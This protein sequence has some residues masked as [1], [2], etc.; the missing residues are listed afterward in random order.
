MKKLITTIISLMFFGNLVFAQLTEFSMGDILS[1]GA[2]NQNFKYLENRFGGIRET[3][4]NCGTSGSGSG[5]NSAIQNGYNSIVING[6][7][8]ENIKL[9]GREGN[10]PRLLKLRGANNDYTKDKIIDNSSYTDHVVNVLFNGIVVT[11]DNLTLSG[12]IRTVR[13]WGPNMFRMENVKVNDYKQRGIHMTE[14]SVIDGYNLIIDGS[15][16]S[17]DSSERGIWLALQSYGWFENLQISNNT[18]CGLCV[19]ENSQTRLVGTNSFSGNGIGI[20][21]GLASSLANSSNITIDNSADYGVHVK[22]GMVN[23]PVGFGVN[24]SITITNTTSGKAFNAWLSNIAISDLTATGDGSTEESLVVINQSSSIF[25]NLNI[26]NS[27]NDG[28]ESDQSV[29]HVDKLTAKNNQGDGIDANSTTLTVNNSTISDN[30]G[31]GISASRS[32]ITVKNSVIS[33]N[34]DDGIEL[35]SGSNLSLESSTIS[36]NSDDGI[37]AYENNYIF[38]NKSTI[39]SNSSEAIAYGEGSFLHVRDST[40]SG[41][42]GENA[43]N[44]GN[45]A[46]LK[47]TEDSGSTVISTTNNVAIRLSYNSSGQIRSGVQVTSTG[48]NGYGV[49]VSRGGLIHIGSGATITGD[50]S[51]DSIDG[52]LGAKIDIDYGA[53]VQSVVCASDNQTM[54]ILNGSSGNY[55]SPTIGSNCITVKY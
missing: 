44:G 26:S 51:K 50:S 42:S 46:V 2:M 7:C 18:W 11:I 32:R 22:Q 24:G 41:V 40:I 55:P 33:G 29:I 49:Q 53:T 6:I 36:S 4:V 48:T 12:G 3:T 45:N 52:I 38:V 1:A 47:I 39:S 8:K 5:I 43:I 10:T 34:E 9:D 37:E 23:S 25:E 19:W 17:A 21:V 14:G 27:G 35:N 15:N 20:Y 16:S 30:K 31:D 13:S 28:I 54:V